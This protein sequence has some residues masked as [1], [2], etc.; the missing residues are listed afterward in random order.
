MSVTKLPFVSV[1]DLKRTVDTRPPDWR[2]PRNIDVMGLEEELR[3]NLEGEVRFDA[4]SKAMYAVDAGNY[5][6]VPI[7]VVIPKSKEDVIQAIKVCRDFGAP[8]LSRA[9]GTSIPGQTCN[10]AIVIDWSKYTQLRLAHIDG[11]CHAHPLRHLQP[12]L[13]QVGDDGEARARVARDRRRHDA[14]WPGAGNQHVLA[15]HRKG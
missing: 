11:A 9:G 5:R 3:R 2:S 8:L 1:D 13:V 4:G 12:E 10:A 7:G 6:Q 15:Q 14:D